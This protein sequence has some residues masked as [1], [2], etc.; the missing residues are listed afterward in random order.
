M[1]YYEFK[2]CRA[3]LPI[4]DL[5]TIRISAAVSLKALNAAVFRSQANVEP[6][7]LITVLRLIISSSRDDA[8]T[9][10]K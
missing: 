5:N 9:L 4:P 7:H 8:G 10:P 1:T 6:H 3:T 2:Y